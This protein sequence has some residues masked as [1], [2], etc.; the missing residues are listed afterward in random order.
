MQEVARTP[1]ERRKQLAA[2][3]KFPDEIAAII[4]QEFPSYSQTNMKDAKEKE[5]RA[6]MASGELNFES[7]VRLMK[8]LHGAG[9]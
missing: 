3:G 2:D 4:A 9:G 7:G 8:E 6:H 1:T 5:I